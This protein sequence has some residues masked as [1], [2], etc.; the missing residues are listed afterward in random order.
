MSPSS[1]SGLPREVAPAP[2]GRRLTHSTVGPCPLNAG[3]GGLRDDKTGGL[4]HST[5]LAPCIASHHGK[6]SQSGLAL[7][8]E[9]WLRQEP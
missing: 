4:P 9:V 1:A 3:S 6:G 2:D 7:Q 8:E 5:T